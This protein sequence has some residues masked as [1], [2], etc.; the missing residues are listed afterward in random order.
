MSKFKPTVDQ[1]FASLKRCAQAQDRVGAERATEE[2]IERAFEA[3]ENE[4]N[5]QAV[6]IG[7]RLQEIGHSVGYEIEALVL[8]EASEAAK[9]IEVLDRGLAALP[10]S[11]RLWELLGN[12]NSDEARPDEAGKAYEKAL[13]CTDADPSSVRY[14]MALNLARSDKYD[15]AL[16]AIAP[17]DIEKLEEAELRLNLAAFKTS[18]LTQV[19]KFDDAI[20]LAQSVLGK[21]REDDFTEESVPHIAELH[22]QLGRSQAEGK[23]DADKAMA[24]ALDAIRIDQGNELALSLVRAIRN[25][26]SKDAQLFQITVKGTWHELFE[27]ETENREFRQTFAVIAD[28]KEQAF[29]MAR[30]LSPEELRKSLSLEESE[31]VQAV[32][33]EPKGVCQVSPFMFYDDDEGGDGDGHHH[34]PS[35]GCH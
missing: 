23:E 8:D 10:D 35:C 12:I 19:G 33:E 3:I 16:A 17:I 31:A 22:A 1:L 27:G 15:E 7:R 26:L 32:P 9:A 24:H 2:I 29:E 4:D 14:N 20:A 28:S 6:A 21:L 34:G 25:D 30:E 13:A 5:E 11:W 18:V